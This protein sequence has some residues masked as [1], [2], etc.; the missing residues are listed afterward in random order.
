MGVRRRC[1]R[2]ARKCW[3]TAATK[4]MWAATVR[5]VF[6]GWEELVDIVA[7]PVVVVGVGVAVVVVVRV[8]VGGGVMEVVLVV[9]VG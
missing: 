7:V 8:T 5:R 6:H 9:V 1:Q 2:D 3:F 4:H